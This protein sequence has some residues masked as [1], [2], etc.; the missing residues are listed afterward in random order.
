MIEKGDGMNERKW[1]AR[2]LF[3]GCSVRVTT[4]MLLRSRPSISHAA[5]GFSPV[6]LIAGKAGG[7]SCRLS[8]CIRIG[9]AV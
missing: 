9:G 5:N 3:V 7:V 2:L 4:S 8:I 1:K 6:R